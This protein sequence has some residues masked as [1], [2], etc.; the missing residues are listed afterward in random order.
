ML[1]KK[2]AVVVFLILATTICRAEYFVI[3]DYK[4]DM[5]VFGSEGMFE[6]NETI[7][8]EFSEPRRGIFRNIPYMYRINGEEVK[9]R[10][11]DVEVE[12]YRFKTY[13]EDNNYVVKI[14]DKDIFLEGVQTYHISYKVEKAFLFMEDHTEFYWNIIGDQWPVPIDSISYSVKLDEALPMTEN[15]YYIYTG[16]TG[17]QGKNATVEYF[18]DSF[19][20]N[21]TQAFEPNE[22]MTL[23]INLPLNYIKRPGKWEILWEKYGMG[24][25]GGTL[26]LI[27][28]GLFF[29][30]WSRY[31]KDY[32]I[33]RM[34]QYVPPKDLNPAEA[35]VI[36]D[37]KADNVDIL[38]L[39][40]FWA[41]N[42]HITMRRIPNSWGKDDHELTKISELPSNAGPYET[43]V[44]DGLF[45]DG[46][47]I[48]ISSLEN[49][50][51]EHLQA[52]KTSLKT[53]LNTMG[54]YYP[55]SMKLQIYSAGIAIG[56]AVLGVLLGFVFESFALGL[57]LGLS[58]VAGLIFANYM[59]KKNEKGVHLYQQVL[60]FKMFIKAAEKDKIERMLKEDPE[61]FEKTLPYAMIFGYAKQW[62]K[63]FDGL[64]LEP[65]KWYVAPYGMY[66]HGNT[67]SPSEFGSS[68]DSGI[69][70]IQSVFTSMPASSGGGGSFSG[71]GSSGGGFGGG[72]GGSW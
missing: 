52:A 60:G 71:G 48:L 51:Y 8:V 59:L 33:V 40:P 53:H 46:D 20:G 29:R 14:G 1:Y 12:G 45:S 57:G 49:S 42:G 47:K 30:T 54:I 7:T 25:I 23:A 64:L 41:H 69:R 15:D 67:F 9:I 16:A 28:T 39:L 38:A 55:V 10:I 18:L 32:P 61:Y 26:F 24:S 70:D 17:T 5:K 62:S 13:T 19:K 11:Y 4:V 6:V 43:I 63:K 34:V 58:S 22:G 50:F 36:I 31:G 66:Y 27:I 44:F 65:P 2:F 72:G 21:S 37:E 68:F 35:G 56:L 3:R